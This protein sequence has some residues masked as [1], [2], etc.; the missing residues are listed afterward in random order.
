MSPSNCMHRASLILALFL[1]L[2]ACGGGGDDA[3]PAPANAAPVA[4]NDSA[5][6]VEDTAVVVD[7]LA[8]DTDPDVASP[9]ILRTGRPAWMKH[10][11]CST[12]RSI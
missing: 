5:T 8:N 3:A 6:T 9:S 2:T 11:H 12:D 1:A 10:S 7:V 4:V